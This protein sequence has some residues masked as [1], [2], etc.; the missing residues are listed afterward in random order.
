MKREITVRP[1]SSCN[2]NQVLVYTH[3][4]THTHTH[5]HTHTHTPLRPAPRP[6]YRGGVQRPIVRYDPHRVSLKMG[7][8]GDQIRR[9]HL[10]VLREPAT[11]QDT[12][13]NALHVDATRRRRRPRIGRS[14][15]QEILCVVQREVDLRAPTPPPPAEHAPGRGRRRGGL[16]SQVADQVPPERKR[17]RLIGREVVGHPRVLAVQGRAPQLFSAHHF[18]RC[19]PHLCGCL[20]G[21][22][23]RHGGWGRR[24]V[25][26]R[27]YDR[28]RVEW[29]DQ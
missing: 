8:P 23:W 29:V 20:G 13:E 15:A 17:F 11:V 28:M 1:T 16:Q 12:G 24:V 9:I 26:R 3:T 10:L 27:V 2:Q 21:R 18:I 5:K 25:N 19:R 6:A 22:V 4:H 7:P 14:E